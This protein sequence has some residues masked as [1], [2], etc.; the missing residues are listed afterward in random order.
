MVPPLPWSVVN[1]WSFVAVVVALVELLV[2]V[3]FVLVLGGLQW[4]VVVTPPPMVAKLCGM[5][6][7]S[8]ETG[9]AGLTRT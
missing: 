1:L 4:V 8:M 6:F 2:I 3:W 9:K 5:E 7:V